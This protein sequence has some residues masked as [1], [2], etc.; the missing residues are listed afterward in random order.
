MLIDEI[1]ALP[2]ELL[3][4]RSSAEITAALNLAR[5]RALKSRRITAA[6]VLAEL[7][8]SG[9]VRGAVVLNKIEAAGAVSPECKWAARLLT[10]DGLDIG[11]PNAQAMLAVLSSPA[12]GSVLTP[13]EAGTLQ[14]MAL[15]D[16][17]VDEMT[18]R[19]TIW[20][21]SGEWLI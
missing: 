12:G 19:R 18:V 21:D 16:D 2:A 4:R 3:A 8:V 9:S 10:T 15:Q 20:S 14:G 6:T 5:P 1:R 13:E 11:H 7:P 17:P